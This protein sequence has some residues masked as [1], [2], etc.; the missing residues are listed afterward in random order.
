MPARTYQVQ[1]YLRRPNRK[2][3]ER[4]PDLDRPIAAHNVDAARGAARVA[5]DRGGYDVL[6][7][8]CGPN[9]RMT[10]RLAVK[11]P[12]TRIQKGGAA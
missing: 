11:A 2:E 5:Y 8:S 10:V 7:L 1:A 3:D 4:K 9:D 6:G 12:R